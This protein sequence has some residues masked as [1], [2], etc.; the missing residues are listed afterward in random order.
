MV[1]FDSK[2]WSLM[3]SLYT[4]QVGKWDG[5]HAKK[6]DGKEKKEKNSKLTFKNENK[7]SK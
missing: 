1:D 5:V 6:G 2:G 4:H 3:H 7:N